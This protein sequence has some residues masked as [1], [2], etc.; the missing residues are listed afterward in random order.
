MKSVSMAKFTSQEVNALQAGG[1]EVC[2]M[3][4]HAHSITDNVVSFSKYIYHE[5]LFHASILKR[6]QLLQR[7]KEIYFKEWD[8]QRHSVPDSRLIL[9]L[10]YYYTFL[11]Y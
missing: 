3:F 2:Y 10:C 4:A 9:N 6:S 8:S 7:A 11:A 5:F 1:N